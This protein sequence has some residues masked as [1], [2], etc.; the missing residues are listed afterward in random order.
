MQIF[1]DVKYSLHALAAAK[2]RTFLTMLG[3]IIGV[4]SVLAVSSVGLSAQQLILG[5]ITS[6]GTNLVGVLPGASQENGPPPIA[7]G[8]VTKTLTRDDVQAIAQIPNVVA[9]SSYVRDSDA[10]SNRE[11]SVTTTIQGLDESYPNV[12]NFSLASGASGGRFFNAQ[13]LASFGRVTVL[14]DTVAR[15]LFGDGNPVGQSV[16]IKN[17]A[18]DVIGVAAKRGSAAFQDQDDQIMVP[19]T[20]A[21]RLLLGIDYV[22]FARLKVDDA[23]HIE[24]VKQDISRLLMRRH[25]INDPN[26]ADFSVRGTDSAISI[27]GGVTGAI[28]GFL[29]AVTAISLLVGGINIM[30]IMYVAVRE[31]TREI[32]LRKALGARRG[33]ILS[34]FLIESAI[35][36]VLGGALGVLLGVGVIA[37][38]AVLVRNAG[39]SWQFILPISGLATSMGIAVGIGLVF[40]MA[41]AI[42]ASRLEAIQALRYE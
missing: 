6:L 30:N 41:P 11:N 15:K 4:M 1:A 13:D 20:T 17:I 22:T 25:H 36:S 8:I 27:L 33:R 7:F 9:A 23:S 26:K 28:K 24:A 2:S 29:L 40:G 39:Y 34:Q 14:G 21:Q 5:Q 32:G 31:R 19:A 37:L 12:E 10:V 3:I 42:T 38:V 16:R 18:F 35:V